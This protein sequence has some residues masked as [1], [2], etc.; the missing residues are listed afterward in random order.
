MAKDSA[1]VAPTEPAA[2]E[3]KFPPPL[4]TSLTEFTAEYLEA[5]KRV[6]EHYCELPDGRKICYIKDGKQG[7]PLVIAFHG[8]C[9][10]KYKWIM[11]KPIEGVLLVSMD[12]PGYGG[13]DPAPDGYTFE[14]AAQDVKAFAKSLDYDEFAVMGHSIGGGWTQQMAAGL[15]DHVRGAILWSAVCDLSHPKAKPFIS[16]VGRP[17]ACLHPTKG[18]CGCILN[19]SF[20]GYAKKHQKGEFEGM[21]MESKN[22]PVGFDVFKEDKFWVCSQVDSWYA[23]KPPGKGILMDAQMVLFAGARGKP[24]GHFDVSTITCP[25]VVVHGDKDYDMGTKA[26]GAINY[27]KA[28]YPN[29]TFDIIP[30]YGHIASCGGTEACAERIKKYMATFGPLKG[31]AP[32][33]AQQ[34]MKES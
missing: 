9:E 25:V 24:V 4:G 14:M 11:P 34:E 28:F 17:P 7:D 15:K 12:R 22:A 16:S 18:C 8:G 10:G 33:P 13:S 3:R 2:E 21:K 19:S 5:R 30:G 6:G 20:T 1:K 29:A 32:P 31:G 23:F 27:Y 26:P